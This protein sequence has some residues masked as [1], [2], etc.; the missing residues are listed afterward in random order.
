MTPNLTTVKQGAPTPPNQADKKATEK[1]P[2]PTPVHDRSNAALVTKAATELWGNTDSTALDRY[3]ADPYPQHDPFV[4]SGLAAMKMGV[5]ASHMDSMFSYKIS[6]VIA[7]GDLVTL[8]G[9]YTGTGVK[10]SVAFDMYRVKDGKLVEHWDCVEDEADKNPSGHTMLDGETTVDDTADTEANRKLVQEFVTDV[11]VGGKN[12]KFG[13]YFA[14]TAYVQHNPG[15]AD[16]TAGLKTIVDGLAAG[17]KTLYTKLHRVVADGNFVITMSEAN[18]TGKTSAVYD[19]FRVAN[20]KIAEH[21]DV[22][23]EVPEKTASGLSMF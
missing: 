11:L 21:W 10:P 13:E 12:D 5:D 23:Q 4:P 9:R 14:G 15:I 8:H 6:R 2:A 16:G 7:D 17:K 18:F 22:V 1:L 19:M 20:G 3:F